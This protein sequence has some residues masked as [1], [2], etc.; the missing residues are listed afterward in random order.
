MEF[1]LH[2]SLAIYSGGLGV[3]AGDFLRAAA[4]GKLPVVGVGIAWGEGYTQQRI[5]AGGQPEDHPT[6]LDRTH[7]VRE[8]PIVRVTI[9]GREVP[10]GIW[11]VEGLRNA[12]LYLLEPVEAR[13]HWITSRLYGGGAEERIAQEIVLG[14]GGARALA[15]LG[16]DVDLFHFNEG[17]AVFA[18]L[19]LI[20]RARGGGASFAEAWAEAR[21]RI[22]FT[23]HTPVDAGNERHPL[24]ELV[25]LGAALG[26]SPDELERIGGDPFN[27]TVA[28]L[29]LA[30]R[31]N[32]VAELHGETAR[33]MWS[34][35][36]DA[37]PILAITNGVDTRVWQDA[38][39][40]NALD[41]AALDEARAA[42]KRDL[43]DEIA[44]RTGARL[45]PARLTVGFARRATAYKRPTLLFHDHARIERLLSEGRMQLVY[46]GK[47]HPRDA[48]GRALVAELVALAARFPD[49]VV[50]VPD[51]DLALGRL[52]TRGCDVWLN[53][54]RA[55]LEACGT[56]GMKAAMN[57]ALNLSILDGWWAEG[58]RHGVNG[59]G[60]GARDASDG[61]SVPTDGA[62]DPAADAADAAALYQLIEGEVVPRFYDDR[63]AWR[64]MMR[65]SI[66]DAVE[67]FSADRMVRDY[68]EL[69]YSDVR[70]R[71]LLPHLRAAAQ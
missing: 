18:G 13:D 46:A 65:A 39:V 58:C 43:L 68:Y 21:R 49:R 5:G 71:E 9:G 24:T 62:P 4:F 30:G 56:S 33:K 34:A 47:A 53:T 35:V 40:R 31:A 23:T 28:G 36:A 1:G 70:A 64:A 32:A 66:A 60:I 7:L 10:L 26:C 55:P 57:G 61:D 2:E 20:A 37:A 27:M 38:R 19:E 67:R 44:A 69:L 48:G 59:W 29:R 8:R 6:P 22:V 17:H 11:R 51:Y 50:F 52:I 12:P 42:C 15:A 63:A 14:V 16:V 41:D 54:P 25:R 3:L 45:D